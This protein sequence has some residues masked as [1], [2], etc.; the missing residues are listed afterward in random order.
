[1]CDLLFRR[2]RGQAVT[3]GKVN[4]VYEL[5]GRQTQLPRLTLDRDARII[6]DLLPGSGERVKD[7]GLARVR[8]TRDRD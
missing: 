4:Y 1:M 5:A 3:A 2:S 7:R 6:A 8:I